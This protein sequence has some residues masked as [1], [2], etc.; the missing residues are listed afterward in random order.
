MARGSVV[1]GAYNGKDAKKLMYKYTLPQKYTKEA[2]GGDILEKRQ[3]SST[4][5]CMNARDKS[6]Q[7]I[8]LS[9][10]ESRLVIFFSREVK[11][12]Q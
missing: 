9:A 7:L 12:R 11:H 3:E 6:S 8:R 2:G 5:A 1:S 4:P 10:A